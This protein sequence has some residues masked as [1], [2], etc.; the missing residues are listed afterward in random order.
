MKPKKTHPKESTTKSESPTDFLTAMTETV[1][2]FSRLALQNLT[3]FQHSLLN[4]QEKLQSTSSQDILAATK[5]LTDKRFRHPDWENNA[6][7]AAVKQAYLLTRQITE[8]AANKMLATQTAGNQKLSEQ[9]HYY[10]NFW[11]DALAPTNF[12]PTNP[13]VLQNLLQSSGETLVKG[14]QNWIEDISQG[15]NIFT[16]RMIDEAAFKVGKNVALTPGNVIFQNEIMQLIQYTPTT[17]TIYERPLLIIPP[18]INKYYI[19]DLQA[20][21]S[22]VK[23]FVDQGYLVFMVSWVN[24]ASKE[25]CAK[26]FA[27]YLQE[28]ALAAIKTIRQITRDKQVNVMGYCVGGALL[29]CA[30]AYLSAK[31]DDSIATGTYL[32]TLLDF[33]DAGILGNLLDENSLKFFETFIQDKGYLSGHVMAGIFNSLRANDLIWP[34]YIRSYLK[35]EAP[36]SLDLLYW[37]ADATNIPA[38]VHSFYLREMYLNNKLM[39]GSLKLLNTTLDLSRIDTP[40]YFLAARED[41]IVPWTGAYKSFRLLKNKNNRFVLTGSG[42]VAG[43]INPAHSDKYGYWT[44]TGKPMKA[45]QWF[46][47]AIQEPGSWW[48]D[49]EAW[50]SYLSG[51]KLPVKQ[52]LK[53]SLPEI[54]TAPGN[55]VKLKNLY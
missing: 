9:L 52:A 19:L 24:P 31:G 54:E 42:H 40:T 21:N 33:T 46:N 13:E 38:P 1:A 28:G 35:G 43:V 7:F 44:Y 26:T 30:Q 41:H 29:A 37:N 3:Q 15:K 11:L 10:L 55:Y 18:W 14:Y 17:K 53:K 8:E 32:T 25:Q 34:A 5:T 36:A 22:M 45:E 4:A 20:H 49:W 27:D 16:P 51:K 23:Y 50:L 2:G 48:K 39:Q 6:F 12:A 47:R